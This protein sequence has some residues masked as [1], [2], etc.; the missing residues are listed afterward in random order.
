VISFAWVSMTLGFEAMGG[1][2]QGQGLERMKAD[3]NI[4]K[5]GLLSIMLLVLA[6][7]PFYAKIR[8]YKLKVST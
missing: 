4:T 1:Y 2:I 3:L 6:L 7:S 8:K 5:G